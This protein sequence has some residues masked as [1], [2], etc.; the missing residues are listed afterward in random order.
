MS[1]Q[2]VDSSA[3][4]TELGSAARAR[5]WRALGQRG[6]TVWCTGLPAAGKSTL[7]ARLERALTIAGRPAYVI[8]GDE[9]RRGLCRDLGFSHADRDENVRRAGEVACLFAEAGVIALVAMVSPF[10]DH[11][12]RVRERH[13]RAGLPF[14]EVWVNTPLAECARRD[15][16]DLYRRARAGELRG[17]TGVDD[18][19]EPPEAPELV[20]AP[21]SAARASE[22]VLALLAPSALS[23][24]RVPAPEEE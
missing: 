10:R 12:R 23:R 1:E 14:F 19:Y 24:Q 15:P 21:G 20:I 6:A 8:D 17:L 11:R 16:K 18:P 13:Q 22:A 2:A 7:A 4:R 3:L 5:R 9:L